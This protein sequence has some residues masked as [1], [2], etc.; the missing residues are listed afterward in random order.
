MRSLHLN[1]IK[2]LLDELNHRLWAGPYHSTSVPD[3]TNAPVA[4]REQIRAAS[5]LVENLPRRV[6]VVIAAY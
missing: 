5:L 4:E 1:P 2:H 6:E 3:L